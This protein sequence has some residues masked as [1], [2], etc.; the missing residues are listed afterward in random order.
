MIKELIDK[1]FNMI[2]KIVII[3]LLI[4]IIGLFIFIVIFVP[5]E[6][7]VEVPVEVEKIIEKET[8]ETYQVDIKGAVKKPG[9][10]VMNFDDRVID[11]I[12]MA[13]GLLKESDTRFLN[14]S[15][16]I[17]DEMVVVIYT[18]SEIKEIKESEIKIKEVIKYIEKDCLCPE[19]EFNDACFCSEIEETNNL[20]SL[21]TATME[22]LMT[23]TGI[24]ESK[25]K[26]IIKYREDNGSFTSL[27]QLK[28][29]SG[30][31][32]SIFDKVKEDITL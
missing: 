29:I 17:F 16:K 25:A 20:I 5:K 27:D 14:L 6:K 4:I 30:I 10:Y 2:N 15:K 19:P 26:A 1:Y 13:G 22:E 9:V 11:V 21:N 31:G 32:D 12:E 24:G 18:Q 28:E 8:E 3:S 23:L 7:V